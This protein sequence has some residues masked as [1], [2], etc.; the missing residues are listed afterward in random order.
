MV[1]LLTVHP[2]GNR[3]LVATL[4]R[5]KWR[6]R[7]LLTLPQ[8][9]MARTSVPSN[10]L[11]IYETYLKVKKTPVSLNL[12]MQSYIMTLTSVIPPT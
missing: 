11:I 5:Y 9:P 6:G 2:P 12:K 1:Y 8:K 4:G 3:D 10:R 7:E